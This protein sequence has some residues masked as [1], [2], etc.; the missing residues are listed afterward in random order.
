M[1]VRSEYRS[2]CGQYIVD[3]FP[4]LNQYILTSIP[5]PVASAKK[6][7]PTDRKPDLDRNVIRRRDRDHRRRI[8][9]AR[10]RPGSTG[11]R[12][13]GRSPRLWTSRWRSSRRVIPRSEPT[14]WGVNRR[15]N[16]SP[17]R[18]PKGTPLIDEFWRWRSRCRS[19]S[20]LRRRRERGLFDDQLRFLNRQLSLPVSMISQ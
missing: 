1:E 3:V 6:S 8:G 7:L 16:G 9:T 2:I 13:C 4:N 17:D 20:G 11:R 18:H 10:S 12:R 14:S 19:W 5:D 15:W